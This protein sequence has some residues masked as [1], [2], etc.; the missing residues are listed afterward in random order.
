[1]GFHSSDVSVPCR[2]K[3]KHK[4]KGVGAGKGTFAEMKVQNW[5]VYNITINV[6]VREGMKWKHKTNTANIRYQREM[7]KC[8]SHNA[9]GKCSVA[10]R[11][12]PESRLMVP[13]CRTFSP[14]RARPVMTGSAQRDV[15]KLSRW[16]SFFFPRSL[17]L[18]RTERSSLGCG[19][20]TDVLYVRMCQCLIW[21]LHCRFKKHVT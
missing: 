21:G 9:F 13:Q 20:L 14:S 18:W 10:R 16:M 3:L 2:H 8:N 4:M 15:V 7:Q 1:M 12:W 6:T 11:V 17:L 19:C 5:E